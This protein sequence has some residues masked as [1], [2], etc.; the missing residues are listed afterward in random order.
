MCLVRELGAKGAEPP[1]SL[2]V[3]H[4]RVGRRGRR[5]DEEPRLAEAALLEPVLGSV[6]VGKE[7]PEVVAR[8]REVRCRGRRAKAGLIP[9]KNWLSLAAFVPKERGSK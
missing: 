2:L 3:G 8:V 6:R 4:R 1:E 9:Q 7:P 5:E